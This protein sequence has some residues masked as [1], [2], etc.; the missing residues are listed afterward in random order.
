VQS[1]G[2]AFGSRPRPVWPGPAAEA[3]HGAQPGARTVVIVHRPLAV[4]RPARAH[5]R[6]FLGEV[7]TVGAG[8]RFKDGDSPGRCGDGGAVESTSDEGFWWPAASCPCPYSIA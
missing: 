8:K 5:R 4:V 2:P 7:F 1:A 6:R 3:A